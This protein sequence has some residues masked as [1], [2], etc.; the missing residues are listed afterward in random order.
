MRPV[1]VGLIG[2]G[3]HARTVLIPALALVPELRLA[4]VATSR[5]ETAREAAER[6]R[7]DGYA[8]YRQLLARADIEAVIIATPFET[9]LEIC[10]EALAHGKHVLIETP[11]IHDT[12]G[13]RSLAA[14][15][16]KRSLVAQ[17]AYMFRYSTAF[18][19]LRQY[20]DD[21]QPPRLFCYDF[22]PFLAHI[23]DLALY[24]SGP[25]DHVLCATQ[26][27][28]G[29]T[30]TLR[31]QNGDTAVVIGRPLANCSV[32]IESV[33]ISTRDFYGAVQGRRRVRI[34][35]GM[36]PVGVEKWS[37]GASGGWS[38]EP[39]I[40]GAR[41][42]ESSGT[43]PLLRAFASAIRNGTTPRSTLADSIETNLLL[44]EVTRKQ[45]EA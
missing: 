27:A 39:H 9:H 30:A 28:A 11:G 6:Y 4:A 31:F 23:Y 38:Y 18:D 13:A 24:L 19:V 8:D 21:Q 40:F 36:Q 12:E 20:L 35:E 26:D 43:A 7:V 22:Y 29:T 1:P 10:R 25:L 14:L 17:V 44:E 34:V 3:F 33:A 2:V 37:V 5:E 41:Y 16:Q 32:D 15:A 42:L 45:N